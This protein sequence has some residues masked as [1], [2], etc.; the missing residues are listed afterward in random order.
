ML[1]LLPVRIMKCPLQGG[2]YFIILVGRITQHCGLEFAA[3]S[4][5]AVKDGV[6]SG[7]VGVGFVVNY[8]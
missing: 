2:G 6:G 7:K 8:E 1:S 5:L 3:C 4:F